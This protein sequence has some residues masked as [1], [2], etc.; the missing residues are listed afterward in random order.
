M[1]VP[2]WFCDHLIEWGKW[3][4]LH[5]LGKLGYGQRIAYSAH[6][7]SLTPSITD[8]ECWKI[9]RALAALHRLDLRSHDVVVYYYICGMSE[10]AIAGVVGGS[11]STVN[12]IRH[13][14]RQHLFNEHEK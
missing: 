3:S 10:H 2:E 11:Q 7:K 5:G 6:S 13:N 1:S 4:R 8:D 12:R 9:N 14:A